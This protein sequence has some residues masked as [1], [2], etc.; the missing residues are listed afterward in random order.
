MQQAA[1]EWIARHGYVGIFSLLVF[2]IVGL[3]VPDEWLLTFSGYLVFRQTLDFVPTVVAAFLGSSCGIS[4]SYVLGRGLGTYVLEKYGRFVH[5]THQ[6]LDQ[7]RDWFSRL[8]RW[9][10]VFGYF[11]PG[12]RH[13]TA[14]VA[15]ASHLRFDRFA[16]F[17]Y[18]GAMLWVLTFI[19][20]GYVLGEQWN[21]FSDRLSNDSLI[22]FAVVAALIGVYVA[23][24]WRR[25]H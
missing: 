15:G 4:I 2:G 18:C 9:T 14:Y 19:G 8:G 12:V 10:L 1:L 24:E 20:A 6:H 21:R 5:L 7:V 11:I 13:L 22:A 25:K 17:A 23:I 16:V 3:P